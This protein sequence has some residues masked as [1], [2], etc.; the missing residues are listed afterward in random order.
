MSAVLPRTDVRTIDAPPVLSAPLGSTRLFVLAE[1]F[2]G[3]AEPIR[4]GGPRDLTRYL[5]RTGI[6]IPAYDA[7]DVALR[8]GVPEVYLSRIIGDDAEFASVN[9]DGTSGG[10]PY[11]LVLTANEPGEWAN[12]P[13]GGLSAEV[14]APGGG[15][16]RQITVYRDGVALI[17]SPIFTARADALAWNALQSVVTVSLGG[18]NTLPAVAAEADFTGG[19]SDSAGITTDSVA[20][21]ATRLRKD[22]GAGQLVAPGRSTVETS[23]VLL[24]HCEEFNR[25]ALLEAADGLDVEDI[26]AVSV[27]LRALGS[28]AEGVP[29]LGGLW[30][31]H[32]IAPGLTPG[33]TRT[34]PWTIVVAGLIARLERAE[35][36]PN[37]APFGDFGVPQYVRGVSRYFSED[38]AAD[39]FG[40]GVNIV[41]RLFDA[42]RNATFRTLETEG[43]T[44]WLDLAHTRLDRAIHA[45][46]LDIGRNMGSRVI[47]RKV[48]QE[49]GARLRKRLEEA[50]WK[51]GATFGDTADQAARVDVDA[52]NDTA[53][54][55]ARELNAAVGVR[56]S[57]HAEYVNITIAKVPIG[58]EV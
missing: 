57:E 2:R 48:V 46:A 52:V 27:E 3:G 9:L 7:I 18:E 15:S 43:Q 30:A 1:S 36:H 45:D 53:S 33:T 41:E 22:L 35:G 38:D 49:F 11:S 17:A 54:M 26:S 28:N 58:Q 39:L 25:T 21:A 16:N 23:T 42:P 4:F 50:Y 55:A 10:S 29:R 20:A 8:E 32:A 6:G 44:E 24:E 19:D 40:A 37:V 56:M 12:G 51:P 13:T 47:N 34:V 14:A 31:Q 5:E